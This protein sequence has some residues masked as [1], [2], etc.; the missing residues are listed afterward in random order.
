[1]LAFYDATT[2]IR[3]ARLNELA[4]C[5]VHFEG[6]LSLRNGADV[7]IL[8]GNNAAW[9]LVR[10]ELEIVQAVVIKDEPPPFPGF[11][12]TALLPQPS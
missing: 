2:R 11:V 10:R 12:A 4:R 1:M 8:Q 3:F 9:F 7:N 5:C 6:I